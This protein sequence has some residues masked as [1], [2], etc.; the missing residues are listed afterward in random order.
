MSSIVQNKRYKKNKK[1]TASEKEMRHFASLS[2]DWWNEDGSFSSL[3]NINPIRLKYL[4]NQ[5]CDYF[6]LDVTSMRPFKGVSILD[7]GCGGGLICEP[8]ARLGATITGIDATYENII[9]AKKHS[10]Q[11]ELDIEY[12]NTV[13]EDFDQGFKSFDVL[14]NFE[15]IE[16]VQDV[17]AFM[18]ACNKMLKSN[19]LMV[20]STLNRTIKSFVQA[21]LMAEVI[22]SWI[23]FGTHQWEKFLKPSEFGQY[24]RAC[25]MIP[26]DVT[27]LSYKPA[28]NNWT[29]SKK[30]DVNYFIT[31]A[32][33][34]TS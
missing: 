26:I 18:F 13:P 30:L 1:S 9:V 6:R 31:S 14:I 19:G 33:N 7:V 5:I 8:L 34:T 11:M 12:Y 15:V 20:S 4:K 22:L 25:G 21:K 10:A 29:L 27:G 2:S 24:I 3:H 28:R 32:K 23:P 17:S 16:H